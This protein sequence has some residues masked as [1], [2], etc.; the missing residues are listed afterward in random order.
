MIYLTLF[1]LRLNKINLYYTYIAREKFKEN[2][3]QIH[4]EHYTHIQKEMQC[5]I[6]THNIKNIK[7]CVMYLFVL[8]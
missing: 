7:L 1:H 3:V 2:I 6:Y 4:T 5:D 8:V